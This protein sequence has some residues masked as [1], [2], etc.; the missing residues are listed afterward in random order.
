MKKNKLGDIFSKKNKGKI[1]LTWIILFVLFIV[2]FVRMKI[3]RSLVINYNNG[4][5]YFKEADY[6]EAENRFMWA[7]NT[8]PTKN[9]DCKVRIN[10]ALS[11]T[12]PITPESVD[13]TNLNEN[14][15]RLLYARSIL[16]DNDCAHEN[17]TKGHN[18][19]AQTLKEEIDE[20]IKYLKDNV[21]PPENEKEED[22]EKDKDNSNKDENENKQNQQE[23]DEH[24]IKKQE[25]K[26]QIEDAENQGQMERFIY[27]DW[28]KNNDSIFGYDGKSW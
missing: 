25:L 23:I 8:K 11:I 21:K 20:Y 1:I 10:Y 22:E 4:I 18:K 7:L 27:E 28:T 14:I 2:F 19:K 6:A 5:K 13:Y 3:N 9:R 12:T 24:E 26:Q 16:T 15:D 17:D